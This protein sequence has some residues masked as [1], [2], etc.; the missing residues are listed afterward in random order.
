MQAF[1]RTIPI[2]TS[3]LEQESNF[4]FG[5]APNSNDTSLE[6]T[7][8]ENTLTAEYSRRLRRM[9][10]NR[11]SARRS[12][13]RKRIHLE[14]LRIELDQLQAQKHDLRTQLGSVLSRSSL[15]RQENKRLQIEALLFKKRLDEAQT[16]LLINR[17]Q[18]V[19]NVPQNFQ[20]FRRGQ[21]SALASLIV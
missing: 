9:K 15:V 12:R 3:V 7:E 19:N 5:S 4:T 8:Q 21:V 17:L 13:I 2:N 6:T 11:E 1:D 16:L 10:S 14:E 18:R 20:A